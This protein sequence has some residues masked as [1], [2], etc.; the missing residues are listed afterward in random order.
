VQVET[1][2]AQQGEVVH[3]MDL[4]EAFVF[5]GQR[6]MLI[7]AVGMLKPAQF[8]Q[9]Y[10]LFLAASQFFPSPPNSTVNLHLSATHRFIF[11]QI[12]TLTTVNTVEWL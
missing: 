3:W 4:A 6:V 10:G 1:T 5:N 9:R 11:M 7:E 2:T 8:D 12:E